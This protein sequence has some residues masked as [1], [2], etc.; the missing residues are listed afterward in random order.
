MADSFNDQ[1]RRPPLATIPKDTYDQAAR[2]AQRQ[3]QDAE[4]R[5]PPITIHPAPYLH[6]NAWIPGQPLQQLQQRDVS[7]R[8]GTAPLTF[9]IEPEVPCLPRA[10]SGSTTHKTRETTGS[11]SRLVGRDSP[12]KSEHDSTRDRQSRSTAPSRQS[13]RSHQSAVA[14]QA[15]LE[16]LDDEPT[17][18]AMVEAR[19]ERTLF[20][21][22]GQVPPT[23]I[24]GKLP[25]SPSQVYS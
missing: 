8:S 22:T 18:R 7:S 2:I 12:R 13:A 24:Q 15:Q 19:H 16:A 23:P 17:A 4:R 11:L 20:K 1:K 21:R 14:A 5:R 3:Q 9:A 10:T 25:R 6:A